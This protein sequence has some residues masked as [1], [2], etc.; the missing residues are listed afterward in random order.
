MHTHTHTPVLVGTHSTY[1]CMYIHAHFPCTAFLVGTRNTHL[2]EHTCSCL[3]YLCVGTLYILLFFIHILT[4]THTHTHAHTHANIN[5][6]QP[7]TLSHRLDTY[8][9]PKP[10]QT[11]TTHS[12]NN[13]DTVYILAQLARRADHALLR[14]RTAVGTNEFSLLLVLQTWEWKRCP[15]GKRSN[16]PYRAW[17]PA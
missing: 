2:H 16:S 11:T 8:T 13:L 1:I 14:S 9:L 4:H 12:N 5:S 17:S 3:D 15:W 7:D 10:N 6:T